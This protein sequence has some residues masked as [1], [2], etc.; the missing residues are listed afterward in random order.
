ME[1]KD[2]VQVAIQYA[3]QS[4]ESCSL[5][6]ERGVVSPSETAVIC[7]PFLETCRSEWMRQNHPSIRFFRL[8]FRA[9]GEEAREINKSLRSLSVPED[10]CLKVCFLDL[11]RPQGGVFLGT[12]VKKSLAGSLR[13]FLRAIS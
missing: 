2:L 7:Q 11:R 8:W 9:T 13:E 6:V 10:V 5:D 12:E 4:G 1:T 3:I